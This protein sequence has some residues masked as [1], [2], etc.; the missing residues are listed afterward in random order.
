MAARNNLQRWLHLANPLDDAAVRR[1]LDRWHP[2]SG[3]ISF[4]LLLDRLAEAGFLHPRTCGGN[5]INSQDAV[6]TGGFTDAT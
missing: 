4:H 6:F 5:R 1:T 2:Y 3:L